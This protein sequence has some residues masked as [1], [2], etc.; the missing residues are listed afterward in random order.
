MAKQLKIVKCNMDG[1]LY[2][3]TVLSMVMFQVRKNMLTMDERRE[4]MEFIEDT[5]YNITAKCLEKL[6]K[7]TKGK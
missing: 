2:S 4:V 6:D 5:Q 1:Q 3:V 7:E